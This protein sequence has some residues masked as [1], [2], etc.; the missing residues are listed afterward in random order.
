MMNSIYQKIIEERNRSKL[1]DPIGFE[2]EALSQLM[3]LAFENDKEPDTLPKHFRIENVFMT[4]DS[5]RLMFRRMEIKVDIIPVSSSN[6]AYFN[7][8]LI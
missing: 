1:K 5:V 8:T 7:V 4:L 3:L 6:G 2:T